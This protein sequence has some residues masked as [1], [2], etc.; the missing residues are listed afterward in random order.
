MVRRLADS[1]EE[2]VVGTDSVHP[3]YCEEL[4]KSS[5][6]FEFAKAAWLRYSEKNL[7]YF[8]V[9]S[10][11]SRDALLKKHPN[12]GAIVGDEGHAPPAAFAVADDVDGD[13]DWDLNGVVEWTA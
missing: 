5:T 10:L 2:N 11:A 9:P 6:S 13:D 4:A 1:T 8:G 7:D 3:D 12:P